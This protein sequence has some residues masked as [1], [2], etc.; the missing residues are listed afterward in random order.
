MTDRCPKV[1]LIVMAGIHGESEGERLVSEAHRAISRDLL[2]MAVAIGS[3]SPVVLSTND[4][5]LADSV[6]TLPVEVVLDPQGE[7]FHFGQRLRALCR[8][9]AI[10]RV[11]YFGG[12]SGVLISPLELEALAEE[13]RQAKATVVLNNFYSTDFCA[14]TPTAVLERVSLPRIDN[15]L[16]WVLSQEGGLPARELFRSAATQFD[17]DTPTDLRVL[18]LHPHVPPHTRSYLDR[19]ALGLP[20]QV[21]GPLTDRYAEVFVAGRISAATM[22]YLERNTACRTRVLSE[23]RGMRSDGRLERGEVRSLLGLLIEEVGVERF[24]AEVLPQWGAA[25]FLDAR[26]LWASWGLRPSR[27]DR[28]YADLGRAERIGDLRLRR[29]VEAVA[30]SPIPVVVGGHSLVAGGLYVLVEAAWARQTDVIRPPVVR[31]PMSGDR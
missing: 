26:V 18:A 7:T 2:E 11:V 19:V 6:G 27:A 24:F 1:G 30:R 12:G 16:G 5:V 8:Q 17:V 22:T 23:E 25:A 31:A 9:L 3:F 13:V 28:F 20:A 21:L 10:E 15:A 29:F 4:R 14:F